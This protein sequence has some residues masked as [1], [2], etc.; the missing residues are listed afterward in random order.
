[1]K[2]GSFGYL[3][4]KRILS[5]AKSLLLLAAVF[6]CYF[7]ALR[8]FHTNKNIFSIAAALGAL[9]AGRSIVMTIML[10][11][12]RGASES[13]RAAID[14]VRG[15][16][17]DR[18]GYDLCLTAYDTAFSLSH[19]AVTAGHVV[20]LTESPQTNCRQCEDH[21]RQILEK[22]GL[23]G[24]EVR[25]YDSLE[26]YRKALED[27]TA[28]AGTPEA[29]ISETGISE[30]GTSEAGTPEAG[31]S[32]AGTSETGKSVIGASVTAA[33]EPGTSERTEDGRVMKLLYSVSL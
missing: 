7:A 24:Y 22:D 20:G 31:T 19:A 3:K 33:S 23:S 2:K 26:P 17:P 4:K 15:L 30:T 11:R 10:M 1:M 14:A 28:P 6:I 18:S 5:A 8:H 29:G 27:L 25:I 9:P 21:I 13:V 32:E 16:Q 12:A